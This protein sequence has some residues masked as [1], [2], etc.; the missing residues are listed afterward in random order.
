M[1]IENKLLNDIKKID[2]YL[3]G[4]DR[5]IEH[6]SDF[7]FVINTKEKFEFIPN[8]HT[9]LDSLRPVIVK[10]W[11]EFYSSFEDAKSKEIFTK[12]DNLQNCYNDYISGRDLIS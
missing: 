6:A 9:S 8:Y 10:L 11:K 2:R 12:L 5:G 4:V 7:E 1:S 3:H